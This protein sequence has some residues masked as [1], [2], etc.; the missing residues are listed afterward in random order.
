MAA[1]LFEQ[2]PLAGERVDVG[3]GL[4][5]GRTQGELRLPDPEVSR[6]HAVVRAAAGGFE[7]EDLGST[8]GTFVEGVRII[9]PTRLAS[10]A[11]VELGGCRARFEAPELQPT[12]VAPRPAPEQPA[13]IEPSRLA[14]AVGGRRSKWLAAAV[15]L[16]LLVVFGGLF[17]G[18][19]ESVSSA[20]TQS[21]DALADDT[22]SAQIAELLRERFESGQTF[23]TLLVYRRDDGLTSADRSRVRADARAAAAV[24][25]TGRIVQA[26]DPAA[27]LPLVSDDREVAATIIPLTTPDSNE[28]DDAITAIR[29]E[30]GTGGGGL[31]VRLTGPAA[32]QSDLNAAI[33]EAHVGLLA[34]TAALVLILLLAIYRSPLVALIP[35]VVVAISY[36]IA[37]GLIY[38]YAKATGEI[39]DR[40]A[41]TLLAILMFGAGTDYCLLLVARYTA[42]LRKM[43]DHHEAMAAALTRTT[44][45]I[46]ASGC[47]VA[48]AMLVFFLAS[49]PTNS[50]LAAVN[51]I[52]ILVVMVAGVSLLPALLAIVGRRAFWPNGK[53]VAFRR[54]PS[55]T[56]VR[57][58][59]SAIRER[60][61]FWFRLATRV[62][63]RPVWAIV[64]TLAIFGT[65]A[66]GLTTY[67]E[68]VSVTDDFRI[69]ND[70]TRGERLLRSGFPA[71]AIY[72]ETVMLRRDQGVLAD[73]DVEATRARIAAVPGV[74]AVSRPTNR[75][76]DGQIATLSV[77]YQGDPFS[78]EA[79]ERARMLRAVVASPVPGISGLVG[80]GTSARVDYKDAVNDDI[81][82]IAPVVLLVIFAML[83][84][85]LRA[86]VAP[87]YLLATVLVSYLG[88]IGISVVVFDVVFGQETVDP[89]YPLITFVFLVALGV[90]YNIFLM[91]RVREEAI[92]HGTSAGL[93]RALVATGPVITSA[94]LI[95]AG[96]FAVLTMLP[97]WALLEIGIT[98]ALGIL[99]D[100]FVVRTIAVPAIVRLLGEAS[101]WPSR[102]TGG[103]RAPATSGV[104]RIPTPASAQDAE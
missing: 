97:L 101:W 45:A 62:T 66:F 57:D 55:L 36:L 87:L 40:S 44:H 33:G 7:I 96:T 39:V 2:G 95:L 99:L 61:G 32:Y 72:P 8:N 76:R 24:A 4:T 88:T 64:A 98:V 1:L 51:A 104:Y 82:L 28:R 19:L 38:L 6:S 35:L 91:S 9:A 16:P 70:S 89:L 3:A 77:T 67:S 78:D 26:F 31:Q 75:S 23:N 41:L 22:Q 46:I 15:W 93:L 14:R 13:A 86:L 42:D 53:A 73:A 79:L 11:V 37:S 85:L 103:R 21:V 92:A 17:G 102:A 71:G 56:G 48:G 10:G 63:R 5:I 84:L 25:H 81:L 27:P 18:K 30:V 12:R 29:E 65:G 47:T 83:A 60:P 50:Q 54:A 52:G 20:L 90:D 94:G 43:D 58:A 49:L 59:E 80:D 69:E 100:T 74:A 34:A 68:D